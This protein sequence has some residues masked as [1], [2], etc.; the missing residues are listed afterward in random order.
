M[1]GG[2]QVA[3]PDKIYEMKIFPR[4]EEI[5]KARTD[6]ATI[7]GISEML[8]VSPRT[9][10]N[11]MKIY[12]EFAKA[13]DDAYVAMNVKMENL[14]RKALM[15]RLVER[16]VVDTEIIV[17]GVVEQT[18]V[19]TIQP[20]LEAIKFVLK[21]RNPEIWDKLSVARLEQ[22]EE[23]ENVAQ[24]ILDTLTKYKPDDS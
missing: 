24:Q 19:K 23:T 11:K 12:P 5:I 2:G 16:R 3:K 22:Q 20:D 21:S 4:L 6:G 13:M 9:I 17:D 10:Y 15:D 14:A 7:E 8:G 1:E 18:K